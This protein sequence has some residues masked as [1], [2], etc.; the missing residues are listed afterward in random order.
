MYHIIRN[1]RRQDRHAGV[2]PPLPPPHS[3]VKHPRNIIRRT[4]YETALSS[5]I[6]FKGGVEYRDTGHKGTSGETAPLTRKTGSI[7]PEK[8]DAFHWLNETGT[9]PEAGKVWRHSPFLCNDWNKF[10]GVRMESRVSKLLRRQL[11]LL[12]LF[13][14][15]NIRLFRV[16]WAICSKNVLVRLLVF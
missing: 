1:H 13:K 12:I 9:A 11:D 3:H 8:C 16:K 4:V 10:R 2:N 14:T 15:D 6:R 7:L 5:C